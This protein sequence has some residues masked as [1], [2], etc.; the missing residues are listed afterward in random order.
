MIGNRTVGWF[1]FYRRRVF[2][3]YEVL[4]V[5]PSSF[6]ANEGGKLKFLSV[7]FLLTEFV[8]FAHEWAAQREIDLGGPVFTHLKNRTI[9]GLFWIAKQQG[10]KLGIGCQ[11]TWY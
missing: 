11:A 10:L 2:Q 8:L 1:S 7:L 5:T 3:F 4:V 9:Q 6:S